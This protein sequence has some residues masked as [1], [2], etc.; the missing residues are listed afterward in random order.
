MQR[1]STVTL[2]GAILQQLQKAGGKL[3]AFQLVDA[4]NIPLEALFRVLDSLAS[5]YHWVDV[6]K[7]DPKGNYQVELR[8]EARDYLKK[9]GL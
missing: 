8:P 2:G 5:E 7:S 6:D 9:L 3:S 4:T 1:P